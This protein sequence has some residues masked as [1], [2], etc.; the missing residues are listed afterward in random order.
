LGDLQDY[1]HSDP[2][3]AFDFSAY[4]DWIQKYNHNFT[5]LWIWEQATWA[6]WEAGETYF[7]PTIYRRTG[8]GDALDGRPRFDLDQFNQEFF[9]R[10]RSRVA[11]ADRRGIY[12][13]IMLFQGW[14]LE[15]KG[16]SGKNPNGHPFQ[17]DNN[18]N[19]IDGDEDEDGFGRGPHLENP[20]IQKR[21]KLTFVR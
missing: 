6:P 15:M 21:R 3:P 9:E 16:Q 4:L 7:S 1:G 12:V 11:E 18:I 19:E 14:S 20:R 2:P 8:P 10:L 5:R 13:S 17:R